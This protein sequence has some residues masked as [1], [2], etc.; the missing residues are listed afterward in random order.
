[1]T[2]SINHNSQSEQLSNWTGV[3]RV[4]F[5][6]ERNCWKNL[7]IIKGYE[8]KQERAT[9]ISPICIFYYL[10]CRVRTLLSSSNSMT[11]H[12]FFHN[13]FKFSKTLGLAV[14]FKISKPLLVLEHFLT[15]K[16]STD[17][18]SGVRQNACRLHCLI[19]P[20]YLTSSLPFNHL[21]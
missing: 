13:L 2:L 19:T 10:I 14:S 4:N 16:S 15:L 17:T 20:L 6:G 9:Y 5:D 11:F 12:D 1:M 3:W 8:L 21:Q 7:I 18:N